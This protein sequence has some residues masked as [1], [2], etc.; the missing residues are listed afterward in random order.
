MKKLFTLALVFNCFVA[1]SQIIYVNTSTGNDTN[2]GLSQTQGSG[3]TGPKKTISG[4]NGGFSVLTSGE[5]LSIA[6]GNYNEDVIVDKDVQ[7]IKTGIGAIEL[8]SLTLSQTAK[9][10]GNQPSDGA[11]LA[12][13]VT[14]NAGSSISEGLQLLKTGGVINV[15]SGIYDEQL[16]FT[17]SCYLNGLQEPVIS[18]LVLDGAAIVVTLE[19]SVRISGTLQLNRPAGG[20]IETSSYNLILNDGA[21]TTPGNASSYVRTSG[22]G[23]LVIEGFTNNLTVFPVGTASGYAPVL[24][25]DN[26]NT[27]ETIRVR[28]RQAGNVLSFNPDLPSIVNSHIRLEWTIGESEPGGN[29]AVVRFEYTGANEPSDWNT[30]ANRIVGRNPSGVW[31]PG[32]NSALGE[33]FASAGFTELAGTFAVY[34]DFPNSIQTNELAQLLHVFPNP[35]ENELFVDYSSDKSELL[36]IQLL[37]INGRLVSSTSSAIAPGKNLLTFSSFDQLTAGMYLIKLIGSEG[38]YTSRVVKN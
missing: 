13:V 29:D 33:G 20:I 37:D 24:I 19:G 8:A 35:F 4:Q 36:S 14:I 22:T 21:S 27:G 18:N 11:F 16:T 23:N 3:S 10:L 38:V 9:I 34:S 2:N 31:I 32:D 6:A 7:L 26:N 15:N 30:V 12:P 28:V 1:F 25:D 17:K 5:I